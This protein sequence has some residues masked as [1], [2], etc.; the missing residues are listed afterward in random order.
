VNLLLI[1]I[2]SSI[3]GDLLRRIAMGAEQTS[4]GRD[5]WRRDFLAP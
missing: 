1:F 4:R 5:F 3:I 2:I